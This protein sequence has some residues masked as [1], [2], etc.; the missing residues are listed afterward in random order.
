MNLSVIIVSYNVK[1][2]LEQCIRSL[3]VSAREFSYEVWVVD[4]ASSDGSVEYIQERF[5]AKEYPQLH[6]IANSRN[7]GFG[8]ANN[9]ALER[10]TG[11]R[12]LFLN[13][14]TVLT[15][16]TLTDC[17]SLMNTRPDVGAVGVK[18]L[19]ND[20]SFALESRRGLPSPF[21]AF[22]KMSGLAGLF[23]KSRLFGKYYMRYLDEEKENPVDV[24]SGAFMLIPRKVLTYCGGFD[25]DFFM[26]GEDIDLSYR[27]QKAGYVNFY[28]PTPILHYKGESTEKSSYRYV[29]VFYQAMLIFFDKHYNHYS[30]W[31]S[32][33]IRIAIY[34]RAVLALLKQ[35][36]DNLKSMVQDPIIK[37]R[38]EENYLIIGTR[39]M[40]EEAEKL[41][42]KWILDATYQVV[43]DVAEY[44]GH[45][46]LVKEVNYKF[47]VYDIDFFGFDRILSYFKNHGGEQ[48]GL[49]SMQTGKLITAKNVYG[50]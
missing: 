1:C 50:K 43:D 30:F 31:F 28:V 23:P 13:P 36:A 25:E 34:A 2:Y 16:R 10:A 24:I 14:D 9:L 32:I 44:Q 48:I 46:S 27:L 22:C 18:M 37:Q 12:V 42:K 35:Q 26:Y 19:K 20:G 5:S 11:E 15:E 49:Y 7:V 41:C 39:N 33:P 47:V 45:E 40:I 38:N 8:R 3:F 4:N 29:H 17:F 21:T 6:L